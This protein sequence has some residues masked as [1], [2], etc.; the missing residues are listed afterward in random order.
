[1]AQSV[2]QKATDGVEAIRQIVTERDALQKQCATQENVI[3]RL[4]AINETIE[5][6]HSLL[7]AERDHYMK[8]TMLLMGQ[9]NNVA[10]IANQVRDESRNILRDIVGPRGQSA[11]ELTREI[12]A[13]MPRFIEGLRTNGTRPS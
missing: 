6:Q 7:V 4:Q 13:E 1:M 12:E 3:A 2:E 5:R 11:E 10:S 9:I 8:Q